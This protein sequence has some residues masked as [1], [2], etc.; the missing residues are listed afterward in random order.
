MELSHNSSDSEE[1]MADSKASLKLVNSFF[2]FL[3]GGP[4]VV[5]VVGWLA[6]DWMICAMM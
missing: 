4:L 5:G 3:L 2:L 1:H 6:M